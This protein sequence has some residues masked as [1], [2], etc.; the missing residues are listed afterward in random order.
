MQYDFSKVYYFFLGHVVILLE[1]RTILRISFE[2]LFINLITG[3][4]LLNFDYCYSL[5][6]FNNEVVV[7]E[8]IDNK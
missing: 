4:R 3:Q 5:Y 8:F 1:L 7:V 6:F 2:L